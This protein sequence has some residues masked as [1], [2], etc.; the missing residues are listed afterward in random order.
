MKRYSP[1]NAAGFPVRGGMIEDD[2]H[3]QYFH[4]SEV[5]AEIKRL[6]LANAALLERN[7]R[8]TVINQL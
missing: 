7:K 4:R 8:N 2:D 5:L 3:G 6:E 1:C